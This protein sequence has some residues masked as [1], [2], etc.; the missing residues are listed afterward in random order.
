MEIIF[1]IRARCALTSAF[2]KIAGT[3]KNC[4]QTLFLQG[5]AGK[6]DSLFFSIF[7]IYIF[8]RLHKKI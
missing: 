3:K 2:D 1:Q 7:E 4:R 8:I 6:D 5:A